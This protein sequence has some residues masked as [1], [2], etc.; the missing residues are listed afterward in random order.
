MTT[1]YGG[2]PTGSD[3]ENVPN[4]VGTYNAEDPLIEHPNQDK[5]KTKSGG[6]KLRYH[7][8]GVIAILYITANDITQS[9]YIQISYK[10]L[11][12][13]S[14]Y[15]L[16][17]FNYVG[18][19]LSLPIYILIEYT[20]LTS[21]SCFTLSPSAYFSLLRSK[22]AQNPRYSFSRYFR[23]SFFVTL[24]NFISSYCW[25]IV[26]DKIPVSINFALS[27]SEILFVFL[28]SILFLSEKI[29]L[30]KTISFFCVLI[31]VLLV[32]FGNA[33]W[34][35]STRYSHFQT[36]TAFDNRIR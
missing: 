30:A 9:E 8:Y 15:F 24:F 34:S 25:Y 27:Q 17:W 28:I 11:E 3:P 5:Y 13:K 19:I 29:S 16:C 18:L 36:F 26:L 12:F 22:L 1:Q 21:Q 2:L 35:T 14:Y 32:C 7:I 23:V 33:K 6:I 31:G 4:Y 10:H 20:I